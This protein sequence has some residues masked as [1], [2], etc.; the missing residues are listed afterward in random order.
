THVPELRELVARSGLS[1]RVIFTGFVPDDDLVYLYNRAET[2]VQPS[3]MEGFGLPP[4][5][6][7]ACGTPVLSS[8]A[9]SLPE[10]VGDAGLYFD[11]NDVAAIAATLRRVFEDPDG[12]DRLADRALR[13]ASRFSWREAARAL[14]ETFGDL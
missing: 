8:T 4:V 3:L 1:G 11:P 9:G 2:L 6:A 13:R 14:P 7:M 5:E 10:V 12:R